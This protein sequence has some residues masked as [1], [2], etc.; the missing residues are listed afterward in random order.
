MDQSFVVP[1]LGVEI[2]EGV[3][4]EWLKQEG[5]VVK[6][7]DLILTIGTSKLDM[8]VESPFSGTLTAIKAGVDDVVNVG[9][10]I[11]IITA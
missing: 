8:E 7:G 11:A 4:R 10:E 2:T 6:E 9:D 3:I 1:S 5:D